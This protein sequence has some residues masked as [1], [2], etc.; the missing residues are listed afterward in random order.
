MGNRY[1]RLYGPSMTHDLPGHAA[2][3]PSRR[4]LLLGAGGASGALALAACSGGGAPAAPPEAGESLADLADVP[5][6]GALALTTSDGVPI[7]IA[8]PSAGEVVAFS[9]ICT[10]QGCTVEV[11]DAV[12]RCPCHGSEFDALT[13]AVMHGPAEDPLPRVAVA[14]ENGT[15]VTA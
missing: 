5:A 10:H 11:Q 9:A 3:C 12:L 6:G 4:H 2:I 7:V 1:A 15:V 13:G 14:V 8:Q